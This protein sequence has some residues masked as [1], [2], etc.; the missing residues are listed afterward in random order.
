MPR[1]RRYSRDLPPATINERGLRLIDGAI[2]NDLRDDLTWTAVIGQEE[3][4]E[5]DNIEEFLRD[6]AEESRF[7]ELSLELWDESNGTN[8]Y[9]RC[10]SGGSWLEYSCIADHETE[11]AT[12]AH[13]IEGLFQQ[14]KRFVGIVPRILARPRRIFLS[15]KFSLGAQPVSLWRMLDRKRITE[16]ILSRMVAHLGIGILAFGLGFGLGKVV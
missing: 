11:L 13:S 6:I 7:E 14:Q 2:P 1:K 15:P 16:D 9:L 10:E 4:I 3:E 12:L 5:S 8:F